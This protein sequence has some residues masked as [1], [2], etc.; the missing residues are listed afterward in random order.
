[1]ASLF[2]TQTFKLNHVENWQK[3]RLSNA[4]YMYMLRSSDIFVDFIRHFLEFENFYETDEK[5][6]NDLQI[7]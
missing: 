4:Q 1:M 3:E 7:L 2:A 6:E 5:V